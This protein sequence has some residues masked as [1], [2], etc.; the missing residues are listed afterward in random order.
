MRIVT[1]TYGKAFSPRQICWTI[2]EPTAAVIALVREYEGDPSTK[3]AAWMD[4]GTAYIEASGRRMYDIRSALQA[5][6][7]DAE[8][9][10]RPAPAPVGS[11]HTSLSPGLAGL[12]HVVDGETFKPDAMPDKRGPCECCGRRGVWISGAGGYLCAAHQDDY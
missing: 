4:D 7:R 5:A 12:G 9:A 8:R 2:H 1:E 10:S 3:V 11:H 6:E